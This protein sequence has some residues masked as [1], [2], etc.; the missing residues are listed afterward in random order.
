[1]RAEYIAEVVAVRMGP[2]VM[3]VRKAPIASMP[4]KSLLI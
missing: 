4:P 1:M 2:D 3:M